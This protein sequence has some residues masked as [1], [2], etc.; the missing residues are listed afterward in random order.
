MRFFPLFLNDKLENVKPKK[1]K[2]TL[3]KQSQIKEARTLTGSLC[4]R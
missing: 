3:Q 2:K 4:F 1:K